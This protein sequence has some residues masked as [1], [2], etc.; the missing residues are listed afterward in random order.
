MAIILSHVECPARGPAASSVSVCCFAFSESLRSELWTCKRHFC[1]LPFGRLQ[2]QERKTD[3]SGT[4]L[5]ASATDH[6][7]DLVPSKSLPASVTAPP[8]STN[9]HDAI[10][11]YGGSAEMP[12]RYEFDGCGSGG[13]SGN[14][15]HASWAKLTSERVPTPRQ[16]SR[17]LDKYVIG[18]AHGKKAFMCGTDEE[19][20][21]CCADVTG[22]VCGGV[23]SLHAYLS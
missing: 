22:A 4:R 12:C 23:Q 20:V 6:T 1:A 14:G 13:E 7:A 16:I 15:S 9:P 2:R 17:D 21:M 10:P 3:G 11:S 18:Q 8:A 5:S 19:A